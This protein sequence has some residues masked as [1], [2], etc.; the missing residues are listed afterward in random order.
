MTSAPACR[1][2][3]KISVIFRIE[4]FPDGL[5]WLNALCGKDHDV[6]DMLAAFDCDESIN[7]GR[8][9]TSRNSPSIAWEAADYWVRSPRVAMRVR[10]DYSL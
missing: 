9:I 1:G 6:E 5:D 7:F 4:A 10:E 2:Q 3:R 8:K